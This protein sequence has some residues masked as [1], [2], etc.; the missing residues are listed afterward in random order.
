MVLSV[1]V[2]DARHAPSTTGSA[3]G[4]W[5][6]ASGT[7]AAS[8]LGLRGARVLFGGGVISGSGSGAAAAFAL[9]ARGVLDR[10]RGARGWSDDDGS[11]SSPG[12]ASSATGASS[13]AAFGFRGARTLFGDA[14]AATTVSHSTWL[15]LG[16]LI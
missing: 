5:S 4:C 10:G 14:A 15:D 12:G 7:A 3:G 6:W 1:P 11:G 16:S 8:T 13:A 9:G 2:R